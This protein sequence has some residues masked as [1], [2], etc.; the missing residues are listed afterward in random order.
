MLSGRIDVDNPGGGRDAHT[1]H[2]INNRAYAAGEARLAEALSL[3]QQCNATFAAGVPLQQPLAQLTADSIQF[4]I[5]ATA[6]A[7][8][9]KP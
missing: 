8:L 2:E 7:Y 9:V 1:A 3:T 6:I 5:I 4:A